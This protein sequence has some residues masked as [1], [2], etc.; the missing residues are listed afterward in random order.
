MKNLI[1]YYNKIQATYDELDNL[2]GELE[3]TRDAIEEKAIDKGRDMTE[4][5]QERYDAIDEQISAIEEC[6]DNLEYAMGAIEEYC[7]EY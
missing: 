1:K 2:I 5:E 3:E 4:K 7:E 6:K